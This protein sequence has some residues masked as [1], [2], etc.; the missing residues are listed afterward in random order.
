MIAKPWLWLGAVLVIAVGVVAFL[1][2]GRSGSG[3]A[4]QELRAWVGRTD[5]G[6][7]VGTL[8]GDGEAVRKALSAHAG[9]ST[10]HT[11]C[12]AM[13]T[14]AQTANDDLPAPDVRL[15]QL[16]A[17][18]YGLAYDAAESCYRAP[19]PASALLATFASDR[20]RAGALFGRALRRVRSLSGL[21]VPTTTTTVP[22]LT[23]TSLF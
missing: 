5:L 11:V 7:V 8:E 22:D 19:S 18:A 20:A 9:M 23:G 6:Q 17:R 13:A 4:S 10:V 16:L 15:T 3:T 14:E 12:A 21:E 2:L 1:S